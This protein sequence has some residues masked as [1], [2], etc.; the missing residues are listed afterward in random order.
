MRQHRRRAAWREP[1]K[2]SGAASLDIER[3][4]IGIRGAT[5]AKKEAENVI[6]ELNG[7]F[8]ELYVAV[9]VRHSLSTHVN[10][11]PHLARTDTTHRDVAS[12]EHHAD[13]NP[14]A[15]SLCSPTTQKSVSNSASSSS[16]SAA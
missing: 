13:Y 8:G 7:V 15:W 3:G 14:Q 12:L 4:V 6:G 9:A 16:T 10:S 1:Y 2:V 11:R 5:R